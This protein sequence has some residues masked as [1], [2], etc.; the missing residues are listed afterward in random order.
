MTNETDAAEK[1][2]EKHSAFRAPILGL[3]FILVGLALLLR[4][5]VPEPTIARLWPLFLLVP[6]LVLGTQLIEKGKGAAGVLVPMGI[7]SYL[8]VYFLWL[9][10]STWAHTAE[11]WP[12]FLLAPAFGLFLLY[13]ATR[14]TSLLVPVLILTVL[15][16]VF[17]GGIQRSSVA[18]AVIFIAVGLVILAG[19]LL[20]KR[21]G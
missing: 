6:V 8:T 19:P 1:P 20:R 4:P 16:G 12:H 3:L 5:L 2:A 15:A 11:T 13:L 21:G 7:L 9:N 10:F 17:L 18:M 14:N